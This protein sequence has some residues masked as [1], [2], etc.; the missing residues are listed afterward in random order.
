VH[1]VVSSR[2]YK[3]SV[4]CYT[5]KRMDAQPNAIKAIGTIRVSRVKGRDGDSFASDA[6]YE[7]AAVVATLTYREP[8]RSSRQGWRSRTADWVVKPE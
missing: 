3:H 5:E 7:D 8:Q 6:Q 2:C 4:G 1:T